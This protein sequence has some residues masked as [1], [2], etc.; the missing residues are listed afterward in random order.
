MKKHIKNPKN[1]DKPATRADVK[2]IVA[3]I[4]TEIIGGTVPGMVTSIVT[5]IVDSRIESL[6]IMV[7]RGFDDI[8][9]RMATKDELN[10][11]REEVAAFDR[12]ITGRVDDHEN[13]IGLLEGAGA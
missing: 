6:A 4:V 2:E 12:H 1:D 8:N 11:F 7:K 5:D 10:A 9:E 13:R 3:E